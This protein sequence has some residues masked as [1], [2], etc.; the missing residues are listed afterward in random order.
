MGEDCLVLELAPR[1]ED[2]LVRVAE[3]VLRICPPLARSSTADEVAHT[4][5]DTGILRMDWA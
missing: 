1:D 3:R 4:V 2:A 5:R